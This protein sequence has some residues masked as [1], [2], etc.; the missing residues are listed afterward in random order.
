VKESLERQLSLT[1]NIQVT[2]QKKLAESL[3]RETEQRISIETANA[4]IVEV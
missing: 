2:L 4:Q 1:E 3:K